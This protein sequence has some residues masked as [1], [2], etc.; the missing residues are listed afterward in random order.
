MSDIYVVGVGMTPFG[1]M[2]DIDMK[3]LS[4]S[5]VD[6]ALG[7]ALREYQRLRIDRSARIQ[8]A[9]AGNGGVFHLPDGPE[10]R[11]RDAELKSR[12]ADFKSYDWTWADAYQM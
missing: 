7:D 8:L 9:S 12:R 5:A 11:A 2:L 10:Q 3:T 1:R 4:R 6:A